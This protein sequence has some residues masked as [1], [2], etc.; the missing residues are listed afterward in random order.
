MKIEIKVDRAQPI[1]VV[2]SL[3]EGKFL[4][5]VGKN[6]V[7]KSLAANLLA[8]ASGDYSF[9]EDISFFSLKAALRSVDITIVTDGHRL[10]AMLKPG[11]WRW[12]EF[13]GKVLPETLGVFRVDGKEVS[14]SEF[15][16]LFSVKIVRGNEGLETQL[17]DLGK[18]LSTSYNRLFDKLLERVSELSTGAQQI[19]EKLAFRLVERLSEREASYKESVKGT[20]V[21]PETVG[22]LSKVL[23]SLSKVTSLRSLDLELKN[24]IRDLKQRVEE[25]TRAEARLIERRQK[26]QAASSDIRAL[27][28]Y[29][30]QIEETNDE[31]RSLLNDLPFSDENLLTIEGIEAADRECKKTEDELEAASE[32][33]Q[34]L[35]YALLVQAE[36]PKVIV[37][38]GTD[39]DRALIQS[40]EI[41]TLRQ[42][43]LT[44]NRRQLLGDFAFSSKRTRDSLKGNPI[45][46]NLEDKQTDNQEK[47]KALAEQRRL[48]KRIIDLKGKL[49]QLQRR[50]ESQRGGYAE[51]LN[52]II[53]QTLDLQSRTQALRE[54]ITLL[55][56]EKLH[57][58]NQRF[59][60]LIKDLTGIEASNFDAAL[61]GVQAKYQGVG[62]LENERRA[63][64][65]SIEKYFDSLDAETA[66]S[67]PDALR[68]L[69]RGK[70]LDKIAKVVGRLTPISTMEWLETIRTEVNYRIDQIVQLSR[71]E[72]GEGQDDFYKVV[73]EALGSIL[74]NQLNQAPF[75]EYVFKEPVVSVDPASGIVTLSGPT[76]TQQRSLNDFSTGEKAFAYSVASILANRRETKWSILFLDEF[77]AVLDEYRE[78]F[79]GKIVREQM[80][81]SGWPTKAVTM[82]PYK[83]DLERDERLVADPNTSEDL[84]SYLREEIPKRRRLFQKA[85]Y[86]S[87]EV[88]NV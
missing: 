44:R 46:K 70:Q 41:L 6:G 30:S 20:G 80:E 65:G 9:R 38:L 67:L 71:K 45:L 12:G 57:K 14:P 54:A 78:R 66:A 10:Q 35:K 40:A 86:Y 23:T 18:T 42:P 26:L 48:I 61:K 29:V 2:S 27:S 47:A 13:E 68:E 21:D 88:M 1:G 39:Y 11:T 73:N 8:I 63:I 87:E 72:P 56:S 7:G 51:E 60:K 15:S 3:P 55:G 53:S 43:R 36:V 75:R 49:S 76:G 24:L 16:E 50:I 25:E 19:R 4:R 84:R 32:E 28:Q 74:T 58:P 79:I 31:I 81:Q 37:S 85:G 33:F 82:L 34:K 62:G 83:G 59:S 22:L 52:S 5:L 77:G 69:I 64:M 17:F